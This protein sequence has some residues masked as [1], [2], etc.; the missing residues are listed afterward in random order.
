MAHAPHD[1]T[2]G[3]MQADPTDAKQDGF[4]FA[5]D[6][7]TP[8]ATSTRRPRLVEEHHIQGPYGQDEL[9]ATDDLGRRWYHLRPDPRGRADLFGV[10]YT[11]W[12]IM[13]I[14]FIFIV[15]LPWGHGWGY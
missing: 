6:G 8:D 12:V 9:E 14:C 15:F 10:N 13:W 7:P 3:S 5:S 4:S 11:W 2:T 1:P